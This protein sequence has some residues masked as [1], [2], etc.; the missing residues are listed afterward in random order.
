MIVEL[1]VRNIP[2]QRQV[3]FPVRYRGV[4][5]ADSRI[6]LLVAEQL[7]VELKTVEELR[8]IHTAQVLSYLRAGEFQLGLLLNFNV[9]SLRQG[10][11]RI[12]WSG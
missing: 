12:V 1:G 10:L 6:D 11:R 8:P 3:P 7:V 5:V 9:Y 2:F 4:H